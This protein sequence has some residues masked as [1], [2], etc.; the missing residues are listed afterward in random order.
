MAHTCREVFE[1]MTE[2]LAAGLTFTVQNTNIL[3]SVDNKIRYDCVTD[4]N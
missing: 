2:I 4:N 1:V 3:W